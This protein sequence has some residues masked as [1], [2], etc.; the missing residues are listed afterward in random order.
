MAKV[1]VHVSGSD[2]EQR[3]SYHVIKAILGVRIVAYSLKEQRVHD[4][5]SSALGLKL[6]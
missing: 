5:K 2:N 4:L 3:T 1:T 6:F